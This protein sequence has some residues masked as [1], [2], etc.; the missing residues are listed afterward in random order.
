MTLFGDE[1]E[2][3][4]SQSKKSLKRFQVILK[5]LAD[6]LVSSEASL[7]ASGFD[8]FT[9]ISPTRDLV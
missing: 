1:S 9:P 6:R 3:G 8:F 2:I 4:V 7:A 5:T